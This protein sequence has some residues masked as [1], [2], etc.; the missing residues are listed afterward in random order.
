MSH[1][2]STEITLGDL[3][4]LQDP[5]VASLYLDECLESGDDALF[6]E[7]L[8]DIAKAQLGMRELANET[9]LGRESLYKSLSKQGNPAHDTLSKVLDALG[10][11]F[12][13]VPKQ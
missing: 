3:T 1:S 6:R 11:R 13:I 4:A 7:A 12:A 5:V 9:A 8:K 10:M 2:S